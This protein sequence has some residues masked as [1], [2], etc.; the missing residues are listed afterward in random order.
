MTVLTTIPNGASNR[1]IR[2]TM[3]ALI[4]RVAALEKAGTP[5]ATPAPAFTAQPS[6]SPGSGTAGS[7]FFAAT[8]G[9]V[10]N[11]SVV[12]RVW[13]L[14]GAAISNGVTALPTAS[15][16]LT[17]Q[18]TASGPGGVATSTV[19]V[20]AVAAAA[21]TPT[22]APVFTAQPSIS[23]ST[24]TAGA[25]TF[26]A[27][28]GTVS[29]G[30]VT[31]R[32]WTMNGNVISTGLT[33]SPAS[34]GTL[35]YQETATGIGGSAT[36]TVL[37]VT[38]AT[39]AAPAP[40]FTAQPSI[41][42]STGTASS[43]TFTATPGT[44]TN[45]SITARAW[46][47]NGSVIS[48]ALTAAPTAAGTLTYQETATGSGGTAQSTV[49]S[50]TVSAASSTAAPSFTAQPSI[51]P[52]TG[53]AGTTTFTA[54]PGTVSNGAIVSRVWLLNGTAI[55][56]GVTATPASAGTLTYQETA[57][58]SNG[59][60]QS[61]V[62]TIT[63]TAAAAPT[64]LK[65]AFAGSSTYEKYGTDGSATTVADATRST[66]GFTFTAM[67][68]QG[69]GLLSYAAIIRS[70]TGLPVQYFMEGHGG[71]TV[72]GWLATNSGDRKALVD[73]IKAMGGC[74]L[75]NWA[76]GFNDALQNIVVSEAQH[77]ANLR[78][79][80]ALIRSET[81]LPNLKI[82]VGVSQLYTG[83]ASA[84]PDSTWT[85]VR[86]AE[87]TVAQDPNNYFSAHWYD[88]PQGDGIH[89]TG[90][91]LP[92][93]AARIAENGLAAL[94]LGGAVAESG[95]RIT[96]A[97]ALYST[98]TRLTLTHSRGTDFT[99]TSALS[100]LL[101]SFDNGSTFV[102]P[103]AAVR[104][105][106]T[107]IDI[108]HAASGG[109]APTVWAF[110]GKSPSTSAVLK[111]NSARTLPLNP[112]YS[113]GIKA[114]S[115]SSAVDPGAPADTTAPLITSA[116]TA[117]QPENA[118]FSLTLTANETVTWSKVGG[119]DAAK[120]T[121]SGATLTLPAQDYETPTDADAN[122]TYIVTVRATDTAGNAADQT[123][124]VTITDVAEGG[125]ST[126]KTAK[127]AFSKSN[128]APT[129]FNAF[130]GD[131]TQTQNANA[132]RT[133]ALLDTAGAATGWT[134]T[135]TNFNGGNDTQGTTTG[136]NTGAYPDAA[137][138]GYWYNGVAA[139]GDNGG[140]ATP[141][142]TLTVSGLNPAKKYTF[143]A[144]G[145]RAATDRKTT[146][147]AGGTSQTI[148]CGQNTSL[149]ATFASL[150]PD[151]TGALTLTFGPAASGGYGYL[152]VLEIVES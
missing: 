25:T 63:V 109:A 111:D 60:A 78:Q 82:T 148:D 10:S 129:G 141:T 122:R 95:P 51:S 71:T 1:D 126:G 80:F 101:V 24:G 124:T 117:S 3:N 58:G 116:A 81:G 16:T 29:N 75:L 65:I 89:M 59:T 86:S 28:A 23:P 99:P 8:P 136:A 5:T 103:T 55:S 50:V 87:M 56:T 152:N 12:S 70:R 121:L 46:S 125:T 19:Q 49:K 43:T 39:A 84:G 69:V 68:T 98:K 20:A 4:A 133:K 145:A 83:T 79:L 11:G 94:G 91:S 18:E 97:Q 105:D 119:A 22:P 134:V 132:G 2:D 138:L 34:S 72:A 127:V 32:S 9:T 21:A 26:T 106:A 120:F 110:P 113:A 27:T 118:A 67:G 66:D 57:S 52:T 64:S 74:D 142:T 123:I 104:V 76:C 73:G 42:P 31:S 115:G 128:I 61:A 13:L 143:K 140:V 107:H 139:N 45:G 130:Y 135:T 137:M 85:A 54:T 30:S 40:A 47:L 6:I 17:Y 131:A 114:S 150:A 90:E 151:S 37:Q 41:S 92:F 88:F 146:Y 33:A 36:S 93:H 15:G 144:F 149:V 108:T 14:N 77:L 53:A 96:A 44:V 38:V 100:G 102:T 112:T 62:Q 7:T 147:T 48:T 35:T